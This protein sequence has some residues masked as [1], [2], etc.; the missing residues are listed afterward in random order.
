[1]PEMKFEKNRIS[2]VP[3]IK[4]ISNCIRSFVFDKYKKIFNVRDNLNIRYLRIYDAI[5][6]FFELSNALMAKH[7]SSEAEQH[8]NYFFCI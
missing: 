7:I 8:W 4:R 2:S 1:M 6:L 3:L 5:D